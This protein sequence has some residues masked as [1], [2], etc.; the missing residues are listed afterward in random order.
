MK[1]GGGDNC[2][3]GDLLG[4]GGE[5]GRGDR[6]AREDGNGKVEGNGGVVTGKK[7]VKRFELMLDGIVVWRRGEER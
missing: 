4:D 5:T 6:R 7:G 3:D 2:G 1:G